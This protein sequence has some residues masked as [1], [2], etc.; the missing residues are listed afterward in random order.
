[1]KILAAYGPLA[2]SSIASIR[3]AGPSIELTYE[4][5]RNMAAAT[6][7]LTDDTEVAFM[8]GL[9]L[10]LPTSGRLRWVQI[11]SAGVDTYKQSPA[12]SDP[13]ILITTA[14]GIASNS[15]AE[16]A[17]GM[18]L[19]RGHRLERAMAVKAARAWPDG[20]DGYKPLAAQVLHGQ[21]LGVVGFGG[22]GRRLAWF[23][24][25]LGM[26]V[27]AV[28]A[29]GR[30]P[31]PSYRPA[32]LE[33]A[34]EGTAG[35]TVSGPEGLN[36]LL[37]TSDFVVIALPRTPSSIGM[38]GGDELARM[39][40]TSHLVNA[41]RGGIVDEPALAEALRN[42]RPAFASIDVTAI[43]PLAGDSPLY[44][45]PNCQITPHIAGYFIG[46]EDAA[47]EVFAAN[48]GRYVSGQPLLNLVDRAAGY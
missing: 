35:V 23:G 28:R 45:L 42:G 7:L 44:D 22:V 11:A 47:A 34:G 38:I 46:Y 4:P 2:A 37:E 31:R 48:L 8:N 12:W 43:E 13:G 21:T 36:D 15:I 19:I 9:P 26:Q 20:D 14:S 41:A 27:L 1:M 40:R 16:Y 6:S 17:L 33:F 3:A 30:P 10:S 24:R 25:A 39:K 18:M 5:G 29:S 32:D